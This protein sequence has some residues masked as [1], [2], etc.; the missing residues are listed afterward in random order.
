[1]PISRARMTAPPS[2]LSVHYKTKEDP[3]DESEDGPTDYPAD[4]GDDDDDDE[5]FGDDADDEDEEKAS[6]EDEEEEHIAPTDSTAAASPVGDPVPSIP[7]PPFPV[8][9]PPTTSPT[10]AE[11]HLGF[12]A[13]GIRLRAASPLPSPTL[14]P[15][16]HP[17]P[18]PLP[19]LIYR[20]EEVP[21]ADIPPQKRLCLSAPTPRFKVGE[22]STADAA[23]QP[24]LRAARTTDYGFSDM[25]DDAPRRHVPRE[26]GCGIT[27]T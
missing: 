10:Y 13:A 18:L 11:A 3:K 9:S 8:L 2:R 12:R 27:N 23:R 19:P 16:H 4:G 14:A 24:G 1:M 26:V 22:S 17:L 20:R 25:V 21:E 6:E 7:S 15:T 5:S